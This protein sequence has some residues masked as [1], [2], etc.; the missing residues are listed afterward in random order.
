MKMEDH[1]E[2]DV[3]GERTGFSEDELGLQSR[4]S[5]S[6]VLKF[7]TPQALVVGSDGI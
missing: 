2:K 4:L 7:A 6:R 3:P 1:A 5:W